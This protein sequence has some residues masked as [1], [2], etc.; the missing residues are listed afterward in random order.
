MSLLNVTDFFYRLEDLS[1]F[2]RGGDLKSVNI[3]IKVHPFSQKYILYISF[4]RKFP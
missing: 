2:L 4:I 1:K 3:I